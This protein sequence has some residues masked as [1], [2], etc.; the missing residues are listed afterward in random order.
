MAYQHETSCDEIEDFVRFVR[1]PLPETVP[2]WHKLTVRQQNIVRMFVLEGMMYKEIGYA[3]VI[4]RSTVRNHAS[5]ISEKTGMI[6]SE[7][8]SE[9]VDEIRRR[10]DELIELS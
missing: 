7:L 10:A 1:D 6:L 5:R 9:L 8:K 3:L 4:E 2:Y